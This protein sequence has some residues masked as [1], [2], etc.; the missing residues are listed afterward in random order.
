MSTPET[1]RLVLWGMRKHRH[2]IIRWL[3]FHA[4][5][6]M[7][8]L[9]PLQSEMHGADLKRRGNPMNA[10]ESFCCSAYEDQIHL[11]ERE[12]WAFIR[13][14]AELY[15]PEQARFSTEDWLDES[16]LMDSPP[17]S[18]SRDWRAV[19]V[20]ASLRL[21]KRLTVAQRRTSLVAPADTIVRLFL[22]EASGVMPSSRPMQSEMPNAQLLAQVQE[23]EVQK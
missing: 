22:L 8:S 9:Q 13:A 11:A 7:R 19:S 2:T 17:R 21:A 23:P 6:V 5:G 20:A 14:V 10:E 15:G 3:C 16:E 12:L 4:C 1:A 18:T